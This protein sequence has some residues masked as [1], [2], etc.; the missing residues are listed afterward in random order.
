MPDQDAMP[1]PVDIP[2]IPE[3]PAPMYEAEPVYAEEPDEPSPLIKYLD[4]G[5][6]A[7]ELE[8][9]TGTAQK[10]ITLYDEATASMQ[11]WL[12]KY[13][14]ALSLAKLQP[15]ANG[16][17]VEHKTFP[18]E[19]AS[20]TMMPFILEAA[21]DFNSR[22]A[23][24]IA[25]SN[26][27]AHAKV[28]GQNSPDKEDRAVRVSDYMNA[29]LCEEMPTWRSDQDKG[30]MILPIIGTTYKRSFFCYEDQSVDSSLLLADQVIFNHD[31]ATFEEA[32][33]RFRVETYTR[34]QVI[35]YIR[36]DQKWDL[37]EDA[38]E[39]DV[40]NFEFIHAETW[41]DLDGDGL[42]EPYTATIFRDS[43]KIVCLYP[44]YDDDTVYMNDDGDIVKVVPVESLTQYRFIP[45]PEGGPMGL[46][47]GIL[48]GP[49]FETINTNVRQLIDS[50]TLAITSANSGLISKQMAS[51]RGNAVKS[52]PIEIVMG[53]LTPV[54]TNGTAPL[55][56]SIV[57][58]PFAG[59]NT[60]LFQ[61]MEYLVS[62]ARSMTNATVN[63]EAQPG[64]A[65]SLYLARLQQALKVPNVIVMRVYDCCKQELQ[66]IALLNYRHFD[67][68]K[69]NKV[70]DLQA[71]VSM[72]KDFD[73][74][75]FDVRMV[76]DPSQ[77]SDIERIN[78][79]QVIYEM[80]KDPQQPGQVLNYRKA[81][82][83]VLEAMKASNIEELAPE[84]DPN[85]KDPMQEM[86][87]AQQMA[88]MEM[89]KRDQDLRAQENQFKG[90]KLQLE[91]QRSA[92]QAAKEMSELGLAADKQEAE[93]TRLYTQSLKDLVEMGM[94]Y[95][96]A[97]QS[98]AQIEE[99]FIDQS[100]PTALPGAGGAM[101]QGPGNESLP[102]VPMVEPGPAQGG[103]G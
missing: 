61:L 95:E 69:Y 99:K 17:E 57:Q 76:A 66:K 64:E 23:P 52:G 96:Q 89:R 87:L 47:W 92:M 40:D 44:R 62:S 54:E 49:M 77:G 82:L 50:G 14:K 41:V 58:L 94:A 19:G 43:E 28:Y 48:L 85:A 16:K 65:A 1:L 7:D 38:L 39:E 102:P 103:L 10:I 71:S 81:V 22:A 100:I 34:N 37:E 86:I 74:N 32:P 42:K 24:E 59:P 79:A 72:E 60:V 63:A 46:G 56:D 88:E 31:Y 27:I 5:N 15:T 67:D 101:A 18:F 55:R 26:K 36:G 30:L 84:P 93:I 45:D 91:Q 13:K 9:N 83:D 98:A 11:P 53:Q 2:P 12:K 4:E 80:A 90:L 97:V 75:D 29:Q 20:L 35:G 3:Q 51:G 8:D 25:W 21:L 73:P 68:E 78:R 70:L 6:I 33:D